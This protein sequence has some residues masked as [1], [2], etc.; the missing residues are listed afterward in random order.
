MFLPYTLSAR[1]SRRVEESERR[2]S[3]YT[4]CNSRGDL[5][6][7]IIRSLIIRFAVDRIETV[8]T[9]ALTRRLRARTRS[10]EISYIPVRRSATQA[11]P[12]RNIHRFAFKESFCYDIFHHGARVTSRVTMILNFRSPPRIWRHHP[13]RKRGILF[14]S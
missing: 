6:R 4:L 9:S 1:V 2:Q 5:V 11:L 10:K 3:V 14:P 12:A 8:Y 7:S 13:R